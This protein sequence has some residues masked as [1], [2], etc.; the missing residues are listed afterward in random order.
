MTYGVCVCVF[1]E[2]HLECFARTYIGTAWNWHRSLAAPAK[3]IRLA[4]LQT[5]R[6]AADEL[7][8]IIPLLAWLRDGVRLEEV[9][10][11]TST[12]CTRYLPADLPT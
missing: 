3:A 8:Q 11:T 12:F 5:L 4:L 9:R 7:L 6:H 2:A 10:D 1:K